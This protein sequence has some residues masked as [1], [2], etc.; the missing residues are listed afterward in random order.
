MGGRSPPTRRLDGH[1][2]SGAAGHAV[3]AECSRLTGPGQLGRSF[4]AGKGRGKQPARR[5]PR[6]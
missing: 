3:L 2:R 5:A 1:A 6:A 4:Q